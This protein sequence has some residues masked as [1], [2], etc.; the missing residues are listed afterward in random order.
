MIRRWLAALMVEAFEKEL[1][2]ARQ[3]G[4][5][6]GIETGYTR[7]LEES[8][9]SMV[10]AAGYARGTAERGAKDSFRRFLTGHEFMK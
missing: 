3:E 6:A 5:S 4:Y 7:G 8:F 1:Q 2:V 10:A 9:D